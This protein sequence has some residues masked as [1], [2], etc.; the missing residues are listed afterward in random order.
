VYNL[1]NQQLQQNYNSR[2][3]SQHGAPKQAPEPQYE[4]PFAVAADA[5]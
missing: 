5:N 4:I 1:T 3:S 2:S